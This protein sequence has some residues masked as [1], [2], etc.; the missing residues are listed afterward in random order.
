MG[1]I[2]KTLQ[3]LVGSRNERQIRSLAKEVARI[4]GLEPEYE[5]LTNDQLRAKTA[6]FKHRIDS[7]ESV[8][9]LM[10]E[11]FAA[12]REAAKRTLGQRH[13]DVQMMG[14]IVL[15]RGMIAEM[16]T[17]EGKTLTSTCPVY[18]NALAQ[19][20]VHVI[21]VND[22]LARR[23]A[24]WMGNVFRMLGM[25]V[26]YIQGEMD[27]VERRQMYNC[28][29]T[30]GTNS[31]FGFD[32]LRD[33]M[34]QDPRDQVQRAL[35]YA[36]IDEVDSILIDE[37]RTPL[38]ISGPAQDFSE[39]YAQADAVAQA[40]EGVQDKKIREELGKDATDR[41]LYKKALEGY[42][43][44]IKEKESQCLLTDRGIEKVER[45]LNIG[46]LYDAKNQGWPHMIE[47]ALR[48]NHLFKRDK[49]YVVH[50]GEEG[51]EIVIVDEFTGRLQQGRRWSDGLHQAIEAKEK[52]RVRE[53]SMTYATVT[54]QNFFRLYTKIAGMTGTAITEAGE[55]DQIY[56]LDVIAIPTNRPLI[57]DDRNDLIYGSEGEKFQAVVTEVVSNHL[58]GRPCL[59][60]TTSVLKSERLAD[61]LRRTSIR[62]VDGKLSVRTPVFRLPA[63]GQGRRGGV[64]V[65]EEVKIEPRVM[66]LENLRE[67]EGQ[68]QIRMAD[69]S[70]RVDDPKANPSVE[71]WFPVREELVAQLRKTEGFTGVPH[72]VLNAKQHEKEAEIVA[73]AGKIGSVTIATNMA[74]RGTDIHLGGNGEFFTK[75]KLEHNEGIT[76]QSFIPEEHAGTETYLLPRDV[77]IKAEKDYENKVKEEYAATTKP[78]FVEEHDKVVRMG[79][80]AVVGTE[81]HESRRIDN[82]LRGR[83]GR[84]GDPGSSQFF[85]SLDDDLMR[86]FAGPKMRSMMI[87]MGLR[88]GE[89]IQSGM[90]TKS[91]ERAQ[92]KVEAHHFDIRKNLKEYD[93]VLDLQRK[94]VYSL[95]Q[96]ILEGVDPVEGAEL[97]QSIRSWL[98]DLLGTDENVDEAAAEKIAEYMEKEHSATWNASRVAGNPRVI[99]RDNMI[100][101]AKLARMPEGIKK[102]VRNRVLNVMER[103]WDETAPQDL[104]QNWDLDH[105]ASEL[106]RIFS[107]T[108]DQSRLPDESAEELKNLMLEKAEEL[109]QAKLDEVAGD[110]EGDDR[111]ERIVQLGRYFLLSTLDSRWKEHLRNMDQLRYGVRWEAQA[112]KDPKIVYKKEG[113]LL[114]EELLDEI[115][116]EVVRNIFHVKIEN[117]PA[118]EAL[119]QSPAPD[120]APAKPKVDIGKRA[121]QAARNL[122]KALEDRQAQAQ[123]AATKPGSG[124]QVAVAVKNAPRPNEA[125]WCGS[126]KKYKKCHK[127]SD[128]S[129]LTSPPDAA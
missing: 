13:Y 33:N 96:S 12:V 123:E 56:K 122:K 61:L 27:N 92:R 66:T 6:E 104:Q 115:D 81:R 1:F 62:Y 48:A 84:Q 34:K 38:I 124:R 82:Q 54:L 79:G 4:N 125:C 127:A 30:Y 109:W 102:T 63:P 42:D 52:I 37:A 43:F 73:Q 106:E 89:A 107:S 85:I 32:Y 119:P 108:L 121:M 51:T 8:D 3:F 47:Q 10:Y 94:T 113:R 59:V 7:G 99:V 114:F 21:T 49:N 67:H 36:V 69:P 75:Q 116:T 70:V 80:L 112:Q 28:D 74:G 22:Y 40:L 29:V 35:H 78:E 118:P 83:C 72:H 103:L 18:L 11:A 64:E 95:R 100:L 105:L 97:D 71:T 68:V 101:A 19:R 93:D 25:S 98:N 9:D 110:A 39:L 44:E 117:E 24:E 111:D 57:R 58:A 45:A 126:G 91:V 129:G 76:L 88:D 5:A 15:H 31:E 2:D 26:G 53:E 17:G 60:G 16:V 86:L 20:G 128:D 77:L 87:S 65:A 46:H 120:Q 41:D 50:E 14:G 90:V 23:D 55:F